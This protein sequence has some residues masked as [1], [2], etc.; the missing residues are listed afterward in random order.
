MTHRDAQFWQ[1]D[2]FADVEVVLVVQQPVGQ[3]TA[4]V[5]QKVRKLASF[6]GHRFCLSDSPYISAQVCI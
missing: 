3:N 5:E 2:R 6:P 4:V 1:S